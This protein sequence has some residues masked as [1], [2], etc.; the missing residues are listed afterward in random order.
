MRIERIIA[1]HS[2]QGDCPT[3]IRNEVPRLDV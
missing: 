2:P 3:V 1:G